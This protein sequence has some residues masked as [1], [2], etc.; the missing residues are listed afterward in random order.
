MDLGPG[1]T[2]GLHE[3]WSRAP[4]DWSAL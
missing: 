1:E 2:A 3:L 4:W